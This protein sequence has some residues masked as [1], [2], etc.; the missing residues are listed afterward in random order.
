M[1]TG[2]VIAADMHHDADLYNDSASLPA[3]C[4]PDISNE[5]FGGRRWGAFS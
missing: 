3:G 2:V 4:R 5:L 1:L